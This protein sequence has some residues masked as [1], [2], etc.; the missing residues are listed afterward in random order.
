MA[1]G[2]Y[3]RVDNRRQNSSYC[4]TV[5]IVVFVGLCL[6]GVWMITSSPVVPGQNVDVPAQENKN[7]LKQQVTESNEINT[8]QFEDNPGDLPEDAT[9]G[10]NSMPEEKPEEKPDAS[11]GDNSMPEEKPEDKPEEKPEDKI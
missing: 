9:K 7:E 11:K 4:S 10:D 6:I 3:S 5:T 8:K 1:L 2:N